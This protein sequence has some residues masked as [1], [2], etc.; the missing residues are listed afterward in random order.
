MAHHSCHHPHLL[1][2]LRIRRRLPW[3]L[4]LQLIATPNKKGAVA[5]VATASF[6]P[7]SVGIFPR[8]RAYSASS[9][10]LDLFQAL[11]ANTLVVKID[12]VFDIGTEHACRMVFLQ[13]D[14]LVFDKDFEGITRLDIQALTNFDREHHSSQIIDLTNH[15]G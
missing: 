2:R 6:Y 5:L 10:G 8:C 14:L 9:Q 3:R 15:T 7:I 4:R 13:D 1:L 12:N 11:R